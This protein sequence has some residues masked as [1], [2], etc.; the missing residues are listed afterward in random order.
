[1]KIEALRIA[2]AKVGADRGGDRVIE[3]RNP[4][5]RAVVGTVPKATLEEVRRA[6]A[7]AAGWRSRLTRA[8]RAG[9]LNRAAAAVRARAGEIAALIT[10]RCFHHLE[11]A[12][13]RVTG[14]NVPYPVAKLEKH[15]LPDLD[16]I[17]EGLASS[18][19][20]GMIA[21]LTGIPAAGV[22]AVRARTEATRHKRMLPPS[23][24]VR[25]GRV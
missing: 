1:M 4:F 23:P 18:M 11:A 14:H 19:D 6:L 25:P 8:E 3:V 9:I 10:E 2:G 7:I 12:P 20:D 13:G 15:H 17:L 16:R 21:G 5:T 22:A 24:P